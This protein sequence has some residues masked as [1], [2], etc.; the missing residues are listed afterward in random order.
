[1][2]DQ[3]ILK[4]LA[5]QVREIS[6]KPCQARK[7]ELWRAHNSL[8]KTG[9]PVLVSMGWWDVMKNEIVPEGKLLCADPDLRGLEFDL[10]HKIFLDTLEEDTIIEPWLDI[11]AVFTVDGWGFPV[12]RAV[13]ESGGAYHLIPAIAEEGDVSKLIVPA[14]RVDEVATRR[15]YE[16]IH[17]AI[18]DIMALNLD[19]SPEYKGFSG[20][21]SYWLGQLLGIEELMYHIIDRPEW[22]HGILAFL[23]DGILKVHR[24]ARKQGDWGKCAGMNQAMCYSMETVNPAITENNV[25]MKQL[26]GFFASQEYTL[27]SPAMHEEFLL[28]YQLPI[29]E[30]FGLIAYGC[31]EDLTR[32]IDIL[33]KIPNLRR[34]AVSPFA[35]VAECVRQ[36][37]RDYVLSYRPNPSYIAETHWNPAFIAEKIRSDVYLCRD[38]IYD[39]TL[40]DVITVQNNPARL[41]DWVKIVREETNLI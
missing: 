38:S 7:R 18:G 15:K 22:L 9:V 27:I 11:R 28:D 8:E 21:I 2:Q 31:C 6:A 39:V 1:M 20:D 26:W 33:R 23:R 37:E 12:N 29:M 35:D 36:I 14:H 16:K 19:K 5:S 40:K 25:D 30:Q 3:T 10:R 41:L 13:S 34:I 32:K 24:E 17:D 4:E